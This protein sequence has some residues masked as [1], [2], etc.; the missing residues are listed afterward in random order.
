VTYSKYNLGTRCSSQIV[1]Q[2]SND[3]NNSTNYYD[4][5]LIRSGD[6]CNQSSKLSEI[7]HAVHFGWVEMRQLNFVVI[8][9]DP[10][11]SHFF[12]NV[13]EILVDNA[14]FCLSIS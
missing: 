3:A 11:V 2:R 9:V 12:L 7:A 1:G 14:V 8:I 13:G 4:M 10:K 5:I 6:I